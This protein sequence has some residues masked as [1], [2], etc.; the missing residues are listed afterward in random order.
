MGKQDADIFGLL[1][2]LCH[3]VTILNLYPLVKCH[4]GEMF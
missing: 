1:P 2:R 3:T 4:S